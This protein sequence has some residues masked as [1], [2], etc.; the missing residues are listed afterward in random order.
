MSEYEYRYLIALG[1]NLGNRTHYLGR[2]VAMIAEKVGEVIAQSPIWETKPVGPGDGLFLN[3]ALVC[4]SPLDPESAMA[5]LLAIEATMGRLREKRWGNRIIDLDLLLALDHQGRAIV[6]QTEMLTLPHPLMLE[7]DFVLI[8]S[9]NIAGEWIHPV[10][11]IS[12]KA[13]LA[14]LEQR[15]QKTALRAL[16]QGVSG[17]SEIHL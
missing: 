5:E 4:K 1:S 3:G 12:I 6:L 2:A 15:G 17:E 16:P 11:G 7:R 9:A 14:H 8:P 10:A 13:S